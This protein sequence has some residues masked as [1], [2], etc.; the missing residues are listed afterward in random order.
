MQTGWH[1]IAGL[2]EYYPAKNTHFHGDEAEPFGFFRGLS[3]PKKNKISKIKNI[4]YR[5]VQ[6]L[7][8]GIFLPLIYHQKEFSGF[9][10]VFFWEVLSG[11]P[12]RVVRYL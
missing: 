8:K 6:D 9:F 11:I 5:I 2:S 1:T 7:L 3:N 4:W 12:L 10:R